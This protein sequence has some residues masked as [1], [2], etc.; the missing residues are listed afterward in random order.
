MDTIGENEV[1]KLLEVI[2]KPEYAGMN[3]YEINTAF[4]ASTTMYR[5][6]ESLELLGW[7]GMGGGN[8]SN[9]RSRYERIERCAK[10]ED[11]TSR[12]GHVVGAAKAALQMLNLES[13]SLDFNKPG[14]LDMMNL[15][16][17]Y[18]I[19]TTDEKNELIQMA[20]LSVTVGEKE[21]VGR[22]SIIQIRRALRE[23][24]GH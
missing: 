6:L 15:L 18:N 5:P 11:T 17:A 22:P 16:E 12:P 20:T 9:E 14:R 23:R 7:A 24:D 10:R 3:E 4:Q 8:T 21:G 2:S 19:L 13:S 1:S